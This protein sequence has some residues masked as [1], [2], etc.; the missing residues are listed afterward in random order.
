MRFNSIY[1]VHSKLC[2][3]WSQTLDVA[4]G[5]F[6]QI[7]ELKEQKALSGCHFEQSLSLSLSRP[8]VDSIRATL[9][10]LLNFAFRNALEAV[11]FRFNFVESKDKSLLCICSFLS[12]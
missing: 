7:V 8:K 9:N 12:K 11:E 5:L 3:S 1:F 4:F 6:F 10:R 2:L